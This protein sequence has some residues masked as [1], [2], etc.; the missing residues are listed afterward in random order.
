[1]KKLGW[2]CFSLLVLVSFIQAQEATPEPPDTD[3]CYA[4]TSFRDLSLLN[5]PNGRT[6]GVAPQNTWFSIAARDEEDT[7][8]FSDEL[9]AWVTSDTQFISFT[10]VCDDLELDASLIPTPIPTIQPTVAPTQAPIVIPTASNLINLD[11][12]VD[13]P[14]ESESFHALARQI[15]LPA[16]FDTLPVERLFSLQGY[17]ANTFV[18]QNQALYNGTHGI[19]AGLD[20]GFEQPV[21]SL[22]NGIA[23][24]G[25]NRFGGTTLD[26]YGV[27]VRCTLGDG[28]LSNLIIAYNGLKS[29]GLPLVGSA[30]DKGQVLGEITSGRGIPILYLE[31]YIG[32]ICG[33][34]AIRINPLLMFDT[35]RVTQHAFAAFY[36][37]NDNATAFVPNIYGI[38]VGDID[39]WSFGGDIV[40]SS[41]QF[42]DV[43]L[44]EPTVQDPNREGIEYPNN[45]FTI[46]EL[47][48]T[49]S[50]IDYTPV[51]L[52]QAKL[53]CS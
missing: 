17:G 46:D 52:N 36:P 23:I 3:N 19:H 26:S 47:V 45:T 32:D 11:E 16:P 1:M 39:E 18:F 49:L 34:D 13:V 28:T 10:D 51:P 9:S 42:F 22:C 30:I 7:W 38:E 37:S 25:I 35:Q 5:I 43:E 14:E 40:F 33:N 6:I 48:E 44:G 21:L 31:M 41:S 27:V 4:I 20:Y 15:G 12:S 50:G 24:D 2:I 53:G 29:T 8:R